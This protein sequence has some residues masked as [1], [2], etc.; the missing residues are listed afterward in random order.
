MADS[1]AYDQPSTHATREVAPD[2]YEEL[3]ELVQALH[4]HG[5]LRLLYDLTGALSDI[6]LI[7]ARDLDTPHGRRGVGN[8]YLLAQVLGRIPPEQ[9]QRVSEAMGEG[10][11][12]MGRAA[13]E[14]EYPPGVTGAVK[15]LRDD[16]LWEALGPVLEGVRAFVEH[17]HK[18]PDEE[19]RRGD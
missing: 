5:V 14:K 6:S 17:L 1:I 18:Q 3:D 10:F 8:L 11:S 16:E 4:R 7:L 15:L 2:A 12:R 19:S 13:P 9:F